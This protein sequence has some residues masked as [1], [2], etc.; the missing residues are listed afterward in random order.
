MVSVSVVLVLAQ[1]GVALYKV[2]ASDT[3]LLDHEGIIK[4]FGTFM[5]V[6]IDLKEVD[7]ISLVGLQC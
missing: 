6:L 1:S 5:T 7:Y 2:I 4:V 3:H